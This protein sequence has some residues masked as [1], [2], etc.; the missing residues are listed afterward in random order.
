MTRPTLR[1]AHPVRVAAVVCGALAAGLWLL[2]FGL[3]SVT[4]RGY[5]WWTLVAG[6]TAWLAAFLLARAGDRGVATGV[7]AAAGVA[8]AVA[9]LSVLAEWIRLGDWPV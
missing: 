8:W 1:E 7:A 2:A 9:A 6:L 4:L 5:L 3:L